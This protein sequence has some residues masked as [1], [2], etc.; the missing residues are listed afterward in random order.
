MKCSF[1]IMA[2]SLALSVCAEDLTDADL[3]QVASASA[4]AAVAVTA[5][6][7]QVGAASS[8]APLQEKKQEKRYVGGYGGYGAGYGGYGAGAYGGG[9]GGYGSAL[10][11]VDTAPLWAATD[12][13]WAAMDQLW[14]A[15]AP[16]W[17]A[18]DPTTRT[19]TRCRTTT[20]AWAEP[21]PAIPT[22]TPGS[23]PEAIL[24]ATTRAITATAWW[25]AAWGLSA[26]CLP[27]APATTTEPAS[28]A[29]S[30]KPETDTKTM[31]PSQSPNVQCLS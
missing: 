16:P 4:P 26:E 12:Q 8:Y 13:D 31:K 11:A 9:Y 22:T 19:P 27:S 7:D 14:E 23:E 30:T 28:R 17:E 29:P 25:A 1:L 20:P 2:I 6:E 24:P 5:A 21:E 10:G 3:E 18:M 15:M